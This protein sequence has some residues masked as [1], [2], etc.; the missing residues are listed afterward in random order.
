[1]RLY[2][3]NVNGLRAIWKKGFPEWLQS[4]QPD[5][6]CLQE[7]KSHPGQ[8]DD[9]IRYYPGYHT[10][11]SAAEKKGYSGVA[12][13]S[14]QKPL[15]VQEHWGQEHYASEG[16]ILKAEYP[17]FVLYN[18]Y[19]PN[20]RASQERLDYKMQFYRDFLQHV[21][22]EHER[23]IRQI[24]CGD[25]NTAHREIDLA[26]PKS[27]ED[28]S[29]FLPE[30]RAWMDQLLEAGFIDSLRHF[31]QAPELYTYWDMV[32]RARERNVGWRID[33]FF[34]SHTLLPALSAAHIH[35]D[36][37]GSDHCPISITLDLSTV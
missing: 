11:F 35:A 27:N 36:V 10:Y 16:R 18:I 28:K 31:S 8:L 12:L 26:R 19:F 13:Y 9:G 17:E 29:G 3:W 2:S 24:I 6:L 21:Q 23:G 37:M 33:Y 5:I 4:T 32:T 20:G 30:E 15:D 7:T 1:M 14:K 34:L 25:V 22:A